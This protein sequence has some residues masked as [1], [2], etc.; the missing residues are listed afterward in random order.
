M[1]QSNRK[2]IVFLLAVLMMVTGT[3]FASKPVAAGSNVNALSIPSIGL[4]VNITVAPRTTYSWNMDHIITTAAF[5]AGEPLPG[6]G[7]NVIIAGHSELTKRRPG[8]FYNVPK[9]K[10]G[11]EIILTYNGVKRTY[12]V[13]NVRT[14]APTDLSP[15]N[16]TG[17]ESLTLLTCSGF[18]NGIYSTRTVV[19]AVLTT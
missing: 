13:V 16:Q 9:V 1:K 5:L 19:Y 12:R 10:T 3:L 8:V 2:F 15:L 7:G 4:N 6:N 11:D 14:V 18:D 17:V